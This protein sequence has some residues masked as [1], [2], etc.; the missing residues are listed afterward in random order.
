VGKC[1]REGCPNR[2]KDVAVVRTITT[3]SGKVVRGMYCISCSIAIM[4]EKFPA[5]TEEQCQQT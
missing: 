2:D 1:Q 5:E 3:R 4:E